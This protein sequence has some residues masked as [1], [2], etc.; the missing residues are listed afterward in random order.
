MRIAIILSGVVLVLALLYAV[1]NNISIKNKNNLS[2]TFMK[3][4]S[5][6]FTPR[7]TIPKKYTCDG[8]NIS[9]PLMFSGIPKEAKSL[10]LIMDDP[11]APG[12]TWVHWVL[13]N[14]PAKTSIEE[15]AVPGMQGLNDFKR[16]SYG[17]PCPPSGMHRY[18][19]KVYALN[20]T[21]YLGRNSKKEDL[22]KAMQN[23]ILAKGELI[24][25]YG[26]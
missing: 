12:G 5:S 15:N 16:Q 17:G 2:N 22:E 13:W 26:K 11:D 20:A 3:I 24:G 19:F 8:K 25:L 4:E 6:A 21:L 10:A 23:H 1:V 14:I 7:S 18:F 9:P